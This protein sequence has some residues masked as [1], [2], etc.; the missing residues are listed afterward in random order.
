VER[1]LGE[2][3]R[4]YEIYEQGGGELIWS[5]SPFWGIPWVEASLGCR[6]IANHAI[7][8][9]HT[10]PPE[11]FSEHSRI[12]E[13]SPANPWVEKMAEFIS[14]LS[15]QSG[16]RY[17]VGMT[18]MRGI[19]DLLSALYGQERFLFRMMES[20]EEVK[21]VAESLTEYWIAMGRYLLD[22][23]P[24]FHGGT[25]A[26]FYG[27]WC[28]GKTIWYQEDA[29]ALLSPA[30]YEQCIFESTRR[31]ADSFPH[32]VI[33]LH[34][35]SFVPIE[36]LM[37]TPLSAIELH[38]DTG[39]AGIEELF[40]Y[41]RT[42]LAKKPLILWGNL[43]ENEFESILTR[44]PHRGLAVIAAVESLPQCQTFWDLAMRIIQERC[45]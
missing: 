8:S 12:P 40:G 6:V 30:L 7:G 15:E 21:S 2:Y 14:A 22:R 5:A 36:Y 17:P 41:H 24:L 23:L 37:K 10:E 45:L 1:F 25:G 44:L 27:V 13:F 4:W 26:F 38:R 19:S 28:P 29:A 31:I 33:H 32:S 16:G 34:P 35:S 9:T 39:G 11:G 43:S 42:V 18:L 3:E 20:P